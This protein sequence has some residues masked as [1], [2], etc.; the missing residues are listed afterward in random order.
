MTNLFSNFNVINLI[1]YRPYQKE[2]PRHRR[3]WD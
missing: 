1:S 3:H 2:A